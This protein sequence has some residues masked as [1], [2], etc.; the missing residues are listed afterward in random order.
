MSS[1][2][3]CRVWYKLAQWLQ[4]SWLKCEKLTDGRRTTVVTIAHPRWANKGKTHHD[5]FKNKR[6]TY[7]NRRKKN[8]IFVTPL[9]LLYLSCTCNTNKKSFYRT[10][11]WTFLPR[12]VPIGSSIS[13]KEIKYI[14]K[15]SFMTPLGLVNFYIL[16]FFSQTTGPIGIKLSRNVHWKVL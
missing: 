14:Q 16:I 2:F 15:T 4:R 6:S 5:Q 13:E 10:I 12:L 8:H 1:N 3:N 7:K 11:Q 9:G